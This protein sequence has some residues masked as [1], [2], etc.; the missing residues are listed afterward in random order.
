ML[1][2]VLLL[3]DLNSIDNLVHQVIRTWP[4]RIMKGKHFPGHLGDETTFS[5]ES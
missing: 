5:D 3:T 1:V 4:G 2:A